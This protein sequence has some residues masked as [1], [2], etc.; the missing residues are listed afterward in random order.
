MPESFTSS[1]YALHLTYFI[2]SGLGPLAG[3][4]TDPRAQNVKILYFDIC[5]DLDQA[6]DLNLK[7][8]KHG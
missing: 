1:T 8:V 2:F 5:L 4:V 3:G 7:S 6:C